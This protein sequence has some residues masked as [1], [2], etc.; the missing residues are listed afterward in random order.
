MKHDLGL[1]DW[2]LHSLAVRCRKSHLRYK[3]GLVPVSLK[4]DI[5]RTYLTE[6][7]GKSK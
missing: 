2:I 7:P 3:K 1:Q 4:G 6:F 5:N